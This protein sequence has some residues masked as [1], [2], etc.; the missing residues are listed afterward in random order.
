MQI[1]EMIRDLD[2]Q[3]EKLQ[4]ARRSLEEVEGQGAER[5]TRSAAGRSNIIKQAAA[6]AVDPKSKKPMSKERRKKIADAQRKRWAERRTALIP[7][8]KLSK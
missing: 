7:K 2:V 6:V 5:P 4:R 1:S 3:I 8:V